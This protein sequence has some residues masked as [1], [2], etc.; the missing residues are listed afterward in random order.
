MTPCRDCGGHHSIGLDA[1]VC[2]MRRGGE[3]AVRDVLRRTAV[4]RDVTERTVAEVL[5]VAAI[6]PT[7]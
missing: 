7:A 1:L 6:T 5:A 4:G 3:A 2:E